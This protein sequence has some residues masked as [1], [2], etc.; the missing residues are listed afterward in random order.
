MRQPRLKPDVR[1]RTKNR[2]TVMALSGRSNPYLVPLRAA[3]TRITFVRGVHGQLAAHL[4][5][6]QAE[7]RDSLAR[8][9]TTSYGW[10]VATSLVM[11]DLTEWPP[12]NWAR[13][14]AAGVRARKGRRLASAIDDLAHVSR[15]WAVSQAF[16]AFETF[17]K[18]TAAAY[19]QTS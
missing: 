8:R 17:L 7:I 2:E 6:E 10:A 19:L 18:D 4:H 13:H 9:R 11:R 5:H 16:E 15:V 14:Y 3:L 12:D 1:Q